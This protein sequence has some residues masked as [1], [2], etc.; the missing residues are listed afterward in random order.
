MSESFH[1]PELPQLGHWCA[2]VGRAIVCADL[3]AALGFDLDD[4]PAAGTGCAACAKDGHWC[5]AKGMC[6]EMPLC[7]A[8]GTG[9]ICD[10]AKSV[11]KMRSGIPDFEGEEGH[12]AAMC[13]TI[14]IADADRIV[15]EVATAS[16]WAIK[17]SLDPENLKRGLKG[18]EKAPLRASSLRFVKVARPLTSTE[19]AKK[20]KKK[21]QQS[22]ETVMTTE[23]KKRK[24]TPKLGEITF[25][26]VAPEDVPATKW[27]KG[28]VS[29]FQPVYDA[30]FKA[31]DY[32]QALKMELESGDIAATVGKAAQ[33]RAKKNG[34]KV[35]TAVEGSTLWLV[36]V[37]RE[38]GA[39]SEARG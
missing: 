38:D 6:G 11:E 4:R 15:I 25:A 20:C 17:A 3:V 39:T 2:E 7:M 29:P 19:R 1:I 5:P 34:F 8:C 32:G 16:D 10:Q 33:A 35:R 21:Q 18:S 12:S 27:G 22:K 14:A 30:M 31:F 26:A 28:I 37:K 13:R 24:P 36:C 23:T 9:E